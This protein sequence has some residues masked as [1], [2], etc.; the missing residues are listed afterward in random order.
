LSTNFLQARQYPFLKL[1]GTIAIFFICTIQCSWTPE[2]ETP[3]HHSQEG[4]ISLQ[5]TQAFKIPPQHPISISDSSIQ[6]ILEG[7]TQTQESGL[8]E[9]LLSGPAVKHQIFS[10]SQVRFLAPQLA[11]A[12]SKATPEEVVS[13]TCAAIDENSSIIKGTVAIFPSSIILITVKNSQNA[14]VVHKKGKNSSGLLQENVSMEFPNA[15]AVL[16]REEAKAFMTPPSNS[17]WIAMNLAQLGS[18][19]LHTS[20]P[21]PIQSKTPTPSKLEGNYSVENESVQEQL[22]EL[23]RNVEEQTKE[24]KRLEQTIR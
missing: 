2:I 3:L 14:L 1:C 20:Q 10:P 19:T 11:Q 16:P 6:E 22:R 15:E 24:I 13:F 9:Q 7:I 5:T 21:K 17:N 12:F 8:L 4:T 18:S 23:R